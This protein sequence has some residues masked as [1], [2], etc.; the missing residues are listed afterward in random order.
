MGYCFVVVT[1]HV[2]MCLVLFLSLTSRLDFGQSGHTRLE[3]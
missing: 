2:D 1:F 3:N